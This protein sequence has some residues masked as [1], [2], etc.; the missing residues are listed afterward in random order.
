MNT[1]GQNALLVDKTNAS[2]RLLNQVQRQPVAAVE[3]IPATAAVNLSDDSKDPH[4]SASKASDKFEQAAAELFELAPLSLPTKADM[5]L[6]EK[7]FTRELDKAGVDTRIEIKLR[8]N[9]E[10]K[11]EVTNDHPDKDKIEAMF[12]N[13]SELQQGFVRAETYQTLQ[14]LHAL[15]QQWQQKVNNGASEEAANL[16]LVQ[17]AQSMVAEN[18]GMTYQDGKIVNP[19]NAKQGNDPMQVIANLR[20]SI[21]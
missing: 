1:L 4:G 3:V 17:A 6:F 2:Q 19:S 18:T 20:A 16:W 5:K 10:G 21:N 11:I 15:H 14:K 12:A 9:G 13:D 8:A 7:N